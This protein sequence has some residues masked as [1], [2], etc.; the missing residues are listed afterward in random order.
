MTP[1]AAAVLLLATF[2]E[3]L[4]GARAN[5]R[6]IYCDRAQ[7]DPRNIV[8][9]AIRNGAT[10]DVAAA[11]IARELEI[12][13]ESAAAIGA[14][15]VPTF[16]Q[17]GKLSDSVYA[18]AHAQLTATLKREQNQ[19]P[20]LMALAQLAGRTDPAEEKFRAL[21]P[22]IHAQPDPTRAAIEIATIA[23]H[24][25]APSIFLGDA[26]ANNSDDAELIDAIGRSGYDAFIS[27]AFG[28]IAFTRQGAQMRKRQTPISPDQ[29]HEHAGR[30][31]RTLADLGFAD[32]VI[33]GFQ[34]LPAEAQERVAKDPH[35]ALDIAAAALVLD[36]PELARRMSFSTPPPG[37]DYASGMRLLVGTMLSEKKE[38]PFDIIIAIFT[39]GTSAYTGGVSAQLFASMLDQHG[40]SALAEQ[41]TRTAL[42]RFSYKKE[43]DE[44]FAPLALPLLT[45]FEAMAAKWES[46]PPNKLLAAPRVTTGED[47]SDGDGLTDADEERLVTDPHDT[48]TDDDGM[49][50]AEDTLPQITFRPGAGVEDEVLAAVF[51]EFPPLTNF[52]VAD[53]ATLGPLTMPKTSVALTRDEFYAYNKKFETIRPMFISTIVVESGGKRALVEV[54]QNMEGNTYLVTKT[55]DG[56]QAKRITGYIE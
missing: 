32:L 50:D 10:A 27:G 35:L 36:K 56:W 48:D 20:V 22:L 4:A 11:E 43:I 21:L 45:R 54:G 7:R 47:D 9:Q 33:A 14:A 49:P 1:F 55:D 5:P 3:A 39:N 28:P 40:Y 44:Q 38:D 52:F 18:E 16:G 51:R 17:Q 24:H 2:A 6:R 23:G 31:L 37:H 15:M 8:C 42:R 46:E 30:Q 19:L 29:L 41:V 13:E 53:R 26:F 34:A 12:S 25:H